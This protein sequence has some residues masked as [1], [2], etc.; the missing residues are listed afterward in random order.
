MN[1]LLLLSEC[2]LAAAAVVGTEISRVVDTVDALIG[3]PLIGRGELDRLIV[4]IG[5]RLVKECLLG[6]TLPWRVGLLLLDQLL[7]LLELRDEYALLLHLKELL[8]H[9]LLDQ[10]HRR[11][12]LSDLLLELAD[13]LVLLAENA[14]GSR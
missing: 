1:I 4:R 14:Q 13:F 9:L 3:R 12:K 5:G 11:L 7:L 10:L 2:L 6:I 8:V